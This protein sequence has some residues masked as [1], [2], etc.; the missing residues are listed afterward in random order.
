[1]LALQAQLALLNEQVA[2]QLGALHRTE[3]HPYVVDLRRQQADLEKKLSL[4]QARAARGEAPPA[5]ARQAAAPAGPSFAQQA[6]E[7]QRRQLDQRITQLTTEIAA[8]KT[9]LTQ[10]QATSDALLPFRRQRHALSNE[11]AQTQTQVAHWQEVAAGL[12]TPQPDPVD[13]INIA[14]PPASP[15]F[16]QPWAIF[17]L[18]LVVGLAAGVAAAWIADRR[19]RSIH[20]PREFAGVITLP[21]IGSVSEIATPRTR[22]RRHMR[23]LFVTPAAGLALLAVVFVA[24]LF[25]W[26]GLTAAHF[27]EQV[28]GQ[29][30]HSVW[31]MMTRAP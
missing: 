19:D 28:A 16:P 25:A 2:R 20:T 14:P 24:A 13:G 31:Q 4:A 30:P 12:Q 3:Q 11:L 17:A 23:Q 5:S 9:Q 27:S 7:L 8:L 6:L 15:A 21:V 26:R 22:R 1:V 18:A 29:G 10:Q